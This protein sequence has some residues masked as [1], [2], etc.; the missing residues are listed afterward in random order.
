MTQ[1]DH[2][3]ILPEERIGDTAVSGGDPDDVP[4]LVNIPRLGIRIRR[5]YAQI[6]HY[7]G[8]PE[9]G[10][11]IPVRRSRAAS[12]LPGLVDPKSDA[13]LRR[14]IIPQRSQVNDGVTRMRGLW[15]SARFVSAACLL[16]TEAAAD[17]Q[18][19][20]VLGIVLCNLERVC[21]CWQHAELNG[22]PER[23]ERVDRPTVRVKINQHPAVLDD[24][25]RGLHE[26]WRG[27]R[28]DDP[29]LQGHG[30]CG[31]D[32]TERPDDDS[33]YA[34]GAGVAPDA[35]CRRSTD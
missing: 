22:L 4:T 20:T 31:C 32:G 15:A 12:D 13:G 3:P 28:R 18:C 7:A 34:G 2:I 21:P 8:F 14:R 35:D 25:A 33:V 26:L 29:K 27:S 16:D 6:G 23:G 9:E 10:V 30:V 17:G 11:T 24:Y 19:R 1:V 5:K